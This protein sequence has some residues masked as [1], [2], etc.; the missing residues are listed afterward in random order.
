MCFC[1][2]HS[3]SEL[4]VFVLCPFYLWDF[5]FF[6]R[7]LYLTLFLICCKNFYHIFTQS[8]ANE[9]YRNSHSHVFHIFHSKV[10]IKCTSK[11]ILE[12]PK[13]LSGNKSTKIPETPETPSLA[14]KSQEKTVLGSWHTLRKK[15]QEFSLAENYP[16]GHRETFLFIS[17]F[18]G[19]S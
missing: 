1:H 10:R 11:G 13:S 18:I 4:P 5:F 2:L 7:A 8:L 17:F 3:F 19:Q 15:S 16:F 14:P 6:V 9:L 12:C